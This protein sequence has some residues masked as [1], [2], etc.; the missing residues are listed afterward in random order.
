[1]SL[2]IKTDLPIDNVLLNEQTHVHTEN[3]TIILGKINNDPLIS[4]CPKPCAC[5]L[6]FFSEY[7]RTGLIKLRFKSTVLMTPLCLL[8]H[9]E[10]TIVPSSSKS[11]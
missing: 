11:F 2:L 8:C 7:F 10:H 4:V 3:T 9:F 1:M 6:H 5:F